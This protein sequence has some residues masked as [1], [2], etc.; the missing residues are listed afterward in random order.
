MGVIGGECPG[1]LHAAAA[2]QA[3]AIQA[4]W[5]EHRDA[6][7]GL[8][9]TELAAAIARLAETPELGAPYAARTGVRRLLLQR[10][11]YHVYYRLDVAPERL[12]VLAIWR[13]MRGHGPRLG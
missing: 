13:A 9:A 6:A 3:E 5:P 11:R 12:V 10:T 8:F 4:W 7:S 2:Q 1:R